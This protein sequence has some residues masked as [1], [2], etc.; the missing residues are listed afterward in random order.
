M[1]SPAELQTFFE[2][3]RGYLQIKWL[4]RN[5]TLFAQLKSQLAK[6]EVEKIKPGLYRKV[7]VFSATEWEEIGKIV[8]EGIL[9]LQSAWQYYELTTH[10]SAQ[11]HVAIPHKKKLVL[12]A[13]PPIKLY[14]WSNPNLEIGRIQ[15]A[16]FQIFDIER[17][18][19]DAMRFRKKVGQE[20]ATEVL[21]TYL[22]RKDR[23]LDK[24]LRYASKLRIL[25]VLQTYL[26]IGI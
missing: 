16:G 4:H 20:M 9:C 14:H 15:K 3:N 2:T 19:C 12:P 24:L 1:K 7:G 5:R 13:Y 25:K 8:P 26:D 23:N 21:K 11:F 22:K 10:I 17:S 18:V 6:G